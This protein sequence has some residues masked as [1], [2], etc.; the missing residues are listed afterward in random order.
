MR[1]APARAAPASQRTR[2]RTCWPGGY[3]ELAA[4]VAYEAHELAEGVKV[5]LEAGI[6]AVL[7]RFGVGLGDEPGAIL[8]VR[9]HLVQLLG[10][11]GEEGVEEPEGL[12]EHVEEDGRGAV[13]L[14][15]VV[16]LDGQLRGLDVPVA[17]VVPEILVDGARGVVEAVLGKGILHRARGVVEARVD[18]AI[19]AVRGGPCH[20]LAP[21]EVHEYVP[22]GIPDLVGEAGAELEVL[23]VD[24]D[25]LGSR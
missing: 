14:G 5:R 12:L 24:E 8:P 16:A 3:L 25:V 11:E 20:G 2:S 1:K 6:G 22:G 15:L 9:E 17:E 21:L 19:H 7:P 10:H 18:P 23:L 4:E 13:R